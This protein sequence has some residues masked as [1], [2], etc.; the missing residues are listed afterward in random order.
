MVWLILLIDGG[1]GSSLSSINGLWGKLRYK[2]HLSPLHPSQLLFFFMWQD[3]NAS[4]LYRLLL[5]QMSY[6][7]LLKWGAWDFGKM[8]FLPSLDFRPSQT[9]VIENDTCAE[10]CLYRCN[11]FWDCLF[12]DECICYCLKLCLKQGI[13]E[14]GILWFN[15][16]LLG[17]QLARF[18]NRAYVLAVLMW[19]LTMEVCWDV[20]LLK[21][22]LITDVFRVH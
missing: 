15:E 21:N 4:C 18:W 8:I 3:I 10:S 1:Q 5:L 14:D 22:T 2:N 12:Y 9:K 17:S 13:L 19:D 20:K 6:S 16:C 11:A 7:L